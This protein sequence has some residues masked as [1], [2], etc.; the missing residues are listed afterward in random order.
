MNP[1]IGLEH[2]DDT[3]R[4]REHVRE[5]VCV[6]RFMSVWVLKVHRLTEDEDQRGYWMGMRMS[7]D[8]K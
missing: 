8:S 3:D 1:T 2:F 7:L 4:E 6:Y 5:T